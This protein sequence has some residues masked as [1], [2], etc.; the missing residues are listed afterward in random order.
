MQLE[1]AKHRSNGLLK[2]LLTKI[3]SVK[4]GTTIGWLTHWKC[5]SIASF[6]FL[7]PYPS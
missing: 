3:S 1:M 5:I 7:Q 2:S 6:S 4:I